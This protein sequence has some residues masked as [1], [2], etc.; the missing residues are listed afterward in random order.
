[1]PQVGHASSLNS[2]ARVLPFRHPIFNGSVHRMPNPSQS[3]RTLDRKKREALALKANI[4]KRKEQAET[5]KNGAA[6]ES[7]ERVK[8]RE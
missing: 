3:Q 7:A 1:M 8:T 2:I 5:A 6:K 4:K